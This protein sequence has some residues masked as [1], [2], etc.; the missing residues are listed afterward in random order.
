MKT[1]SGYILLMVDDI[2]TA[3]S[4]YLRENNLIKKD[5]TTYKSVTKLNTT[6]NFPNSSYQHKAIAISIDKKS[7]KV[8]FIC[9]SV[10]LPYYESASIDTLLSV[11]GE[12]DRID[13]GS[14]QLLDG[15]RVDSDCI[16]TRDGVKYQITESDE[17]Q[18]E[19]VKSF[20]SW[21]NR[22]NGNMLQPLT[23][24]FLVACRLI[25]TDTNRLTGYANVE[26]Y[27]RMI[28]KPSTFRLSSSDSPTIKVDHSLT[29][30]AECINDKIVCTTSGLHVIHGNSSAEPYVLFTTKPVNLGSGNL[31][32]I[33]V[34]S[35]GLSIFIS[36]FIANPGIK[37][38]ALKGGFDLLR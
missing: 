20:M 8:M 34:R 36:P 35:K 12:V 33:V 30:V 25:K 21:L 24:R 14:V 19:F 2:D 17:S 9:K 23:E 22:D 32:F 11:F 28:R 15:F 1:S 3:S 26:R 37:L 13:M 31:P 7:D 29:I 16:H 5:G 38:S 18:G 6:Y 27:L 10:T 4:T